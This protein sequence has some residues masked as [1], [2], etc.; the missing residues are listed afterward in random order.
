MRESTHHA[1]SS[2]ISGHEIEVRRFLPQAIAEEPSGAPASR[3]VVFLFGGGFVGGSIESSRGFIASLAQRSATQVFAVQWRLAPENPYPAGVEDAYDAIRWL[4]QSA[5]EFNVDAARIV[6][7]GVS[8]GGAVAAGTVLLARDRGLSPPI[9][10]ALLRYPTLDDQASPQANPYWALYVSW[11][12]HQNQMVW[13]AYMGERNDDNTPCYAAPARAK[14]LK[15]LPPTHIGVGEFDIL[16]GE[17]EAYA[18]RMREAG[19]DVEFVTYPESPHGF[20]GVP[21]SA[22]GEAMRDGEAAFVK[23]F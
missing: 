8:A 21:D 1:P 4:Q 6:V 10:G 9:A 18:N 2:S 16:L 15:G 19:V 22:H 7:A 13:K 3:A 5:G 14:D 23:R 17:C 12:V 11:S 20:D